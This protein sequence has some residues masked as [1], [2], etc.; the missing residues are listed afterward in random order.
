MREMIPVHVEV[1]N[2]TAVFYYTLVERMELVAVDAIANGT[3]SGAASTNSVDIVIFGN[4]Q[5]TPAYEWSTQGNKEG[6]LTDATVKS[7][8]DKASG[9][10]IYSDGA[11]IKVSIGKSGTGPSADFNLCLHF[12]QARLT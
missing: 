1:N 7:L 8:T 9:K 10:V 4:D 6:D 12:K 5:T 2:S 11:T 3:V